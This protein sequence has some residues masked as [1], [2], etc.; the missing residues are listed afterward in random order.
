MYSNEIIV[1]WK[2]DETLLHPMNSSVHTITST[3]KDEADTEKLVR[4]KP[5]RKKCIAKPQVPQRAFV[6]IWSERHI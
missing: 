4:G 6:H 3:T 1:A 2:E 5:H